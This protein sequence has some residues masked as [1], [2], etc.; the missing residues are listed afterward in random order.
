MTEYYWQNQDNG[1]VCVTL[2]PVAPSYRWYPIT[3]K[4]YSD[5]LTLQAHKPR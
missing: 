5:R 4:E 2:S 1:R 3:P